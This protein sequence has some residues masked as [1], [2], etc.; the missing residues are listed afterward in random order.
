MSDGKKILVKWLGHSCFQFRSPGG[1]VILVDPFLS[2]NPALPE[3]V[4]RIDEVDIIALTHGHADH[5]GDTIEI[6]ERLRPKTVSIFE[7][8]LHLG[9]LGVTSEDSIGMNI[10]GT[11]EIDNIGI[12][13]TPASH[14]SSFARADGTLLPSGIACGY[15][16]TFEDSRRIYHAGDTW[17][18]PEFEFIRR[19]WKPEIVILPIGGHYTMDIRSAII[20]VEMLSPRVVIPMH[21]DTFPEIVA[22]PDDFARSVEGA[23]VEVIIP[24]IGTE[25]EV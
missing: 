25:F 15:V 4:K 13:M 24:E 17:L 20:A 21:Y 10:G 5:V 6:Y 9:S 3:N 23:G 14:S 12:T 11:V 22:M 19:L 8:S 16:F 1:K 7:L 2:G 18:I